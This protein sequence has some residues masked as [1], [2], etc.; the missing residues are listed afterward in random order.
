MLRVT[1]NETET[2]VEM[3]LEGRVAGP[4]ADELNRVWVETVPRL[5]S[6]K[7]SID[8]QGVTYV[9]ET[10]KRVLNSIFSYSGAK[11]VASSLETQVLA[12]ELLQ[13]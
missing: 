13:K 8:M 9:D 3:K 12:G 6:K 1:T 4:W 10:G 2:A 7:L 5:S 11:I